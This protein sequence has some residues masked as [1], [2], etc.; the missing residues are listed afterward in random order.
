MIGSK[1]VFLFS[2]QYCLRKCGLG[3]LPIV[4]RII[5]LFIPEQHCHALQYW[6][7]DDFLITMVLKPSC[8][9]SNW[10]FTKCFWQ[11]QAQIDRCGGSVGG[12]QS[13]LLRG[14]NDKTFF[15]STS[16]IRAFSQYFLGLTKNSALLNSYQPLFRQHVRHILRE[17]E[18]EV[19]MIIMQNNPPP[20]NFE[21]NFGDKS[22][23]F[24]Q[25][26]RR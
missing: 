24:K 14:G 5:G 21:D 1:W 2:W 26:L 15:V 25:I 3:F 22:T 13:S 20:M 9:F 23:S 17:E 19:L 16:S 10:F 7:L 8:W 12:L 18:G 4:P 6:N 11:C